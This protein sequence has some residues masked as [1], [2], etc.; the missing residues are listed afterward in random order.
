MELPYSLWSVIRKIEFLVKYSVLS[1]KNRKHYNFRFVCGIKMYL[2]DIT[3]LVVVLFIQ[4]S[5]LY[6]IIG[7]FLEPQRTKYYFYHLIL[8]LVSF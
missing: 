1:G 3:M 8:L 2:N 7:L 6:G 5:L 4:M